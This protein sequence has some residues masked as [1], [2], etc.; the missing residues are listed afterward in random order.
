MSSTGPNS[1]AIPPDL[2]NYDRNSSLRLNN[3]FDS[4]SGHRGTVPAPADERSHPS[5]S[6]ISE[7]GDLSDH[8]GFVPAIS[9]AAPPPLHSS[10]TIDHTMEY[11]DQCPINNNQAELKNLL[12]NS[13][14][15]EPAIRFPSD[16]LHNEVDSSG[17]TNSNH[18]LNDYPAFVS[19]LNTDTIIGLSNLTSKLENAK[20]L[21]PVPL[22]TENPVPLKA[23]QNQNK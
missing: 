9:V 8:N 17:N 19:T 10:N 22:N 18:Q 20:L 11:T 6:P 3:G 16:K 13:T 7:I 23:V 5:L 21:S 4:N 12:H 2:K 1:N 14:R 15:T